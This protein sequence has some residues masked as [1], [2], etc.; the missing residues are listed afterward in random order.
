MVQFCRMYACSVRVYEDAYILTGLDQSVRGGCVCFVSMDVNQHVGFARE[1][2]LLVAH[3]VLYRGFD[4]LWG[5]SS[6]CCVWQTVCAQ[7][8]RLL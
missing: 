2:L 1:D 4:V 8:E 7:R 5:L 3:L 6:S